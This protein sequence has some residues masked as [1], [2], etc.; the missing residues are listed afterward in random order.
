PVSCAE[1]GLDVRTTARSEDAMRILVTWPPHV[2]S[3]F[4]AG[5]H[6]PVFS[7]AAYLRDKG[8]SVDALDAGALNCHWKEFGDRVRSGGY[9]VVVIVN[10]FDV[11]EGVRRAADYARVLASQA[12]IVTVGRLGYQV[13]GFF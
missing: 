7:I 3:Y 5:H 13:P 4:N 2:P 1:R 12:A 6:L 10:E 8:H 11:I 9:D